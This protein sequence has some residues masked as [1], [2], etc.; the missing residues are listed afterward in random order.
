MFD[1]LTPLMGPPWG[2]DLR[3]TF[4]SSLINSAQRIQAERGAAPAHISLSI[5]NKIL[6]FLCWRGKWGEMCP[7]GHL[8]LRPPPPPPPMDFSWS[9]TGAVYAI[10]TFP[11]L[12]WWSCPGQRIGEGRKTVPVTGL[13]YNSL[14]WM[15]TLYT[16]T[17]PNMMISVTVTSKYTNSLRTCLRTV[18]AFSSQI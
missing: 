8:L 17:W 13:R 2:I 5:Y 11:V 9:V 3:S 6:F 18:N 16:P 4:R 14:L 7:S 1:P 15:C 10:H 12:I